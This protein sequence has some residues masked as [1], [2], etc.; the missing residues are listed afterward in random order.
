M[1]Y[2]QSFINHFKQAGIIPLV[3]A[4]VPMQCKG[5]GVSVKP[6]QYNRRILITTIV[7][8][9]GL[10]LHLNLGN[11]LFSPFTYTCGMFQYFKGI[12]LRTSVY[13]T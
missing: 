6:M 2:N 9:S 13:Y 11:P 7:L 12:I 5:A 10:F 4:P 8:I 3:Q 1:M